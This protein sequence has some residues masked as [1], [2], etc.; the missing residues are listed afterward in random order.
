MVKVKEKKEK[1]CHISNVKKSTI[2]KNENKQ[3][4]FKF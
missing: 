3:T 4:I 1:S 2:T